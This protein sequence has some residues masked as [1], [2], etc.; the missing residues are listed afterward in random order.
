MVWLFYVEAVNTQKI[1]GEIF[2]CFQFQRV[3]NG[4]SNGGALGASSSAIPPLRIYIF[5]YFKGLFHNTINQMV[6]S[7][8]AFVKYLTFWCHP[9]PGSLTAGWVVEKRN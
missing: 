9:T 8:F 6:V 2:D 4:A 3:N 5:T 1:G 7:L